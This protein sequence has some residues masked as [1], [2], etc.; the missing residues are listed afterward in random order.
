MKKMKKGI[1][2]MLCMGIICGVTA[3]GERSDNNDN[4]NGAT[5][6]EQRNENYD[7]RDDN[8]L[9]DTGDAIRDG[10]DDA[11]DAIRDGVEDIGNVAEDGMNDVKEGVNGTR[12]NNVDGTR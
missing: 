6:G 12:N 8:L 11:G 7:N 1:L 4:M 9:D 10:V 5:S 3:C 2:I